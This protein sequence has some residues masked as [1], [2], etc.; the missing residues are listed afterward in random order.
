MDGQSPI[1]LIVLGVAIV[2]L[3]FMN[4]RAKKQQQQKLSFRD[5]LAPGQDVQTIGG[6]VGTVTHVEG[7]LI[8]IATTPGTELRFVRAAIA[9]LVEP[10]EELADEAAH[11]EVDEDSG[12]VEESD[13]T[14]SAPASGERPTGFLSDDDLKKPYRDG[15]KP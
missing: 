15:E 3:F 13:P 12:A 7:D 14:P 6:L 10:T 8:T 2:G 9:K 4:S 5:S 1:L 11:D